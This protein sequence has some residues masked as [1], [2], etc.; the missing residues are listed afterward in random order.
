L[1][2][3]FISNFVDQLRKSVCVIGHFFLCEKEI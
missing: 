2:H 1:F 3:S